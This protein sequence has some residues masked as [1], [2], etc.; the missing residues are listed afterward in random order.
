MPLYPIYRST[1]T[2]INRQN[3]VP[4]KEAVTNAKLSANAQ[5]IKNSCNKCK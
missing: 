1:K 2:D 4:C 3:C 5:Y